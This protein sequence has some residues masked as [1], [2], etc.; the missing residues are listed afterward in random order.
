VEVEVEAA[1]PAL[2][3]GGRSIPLV[4]PDRHDPRL[5]LAVVILSLQA[6][7]QIG[8]GFRVSIAQILVAIGVCALI[9]LAVVLHRERKLAWPASALLTGN[10]VAFILRTPGTHHGDWWSFNGIGL[11]IAASAIS[12]LSKYLVRPGGRHRFNPSNLGLVVVFLLLGPQ[13]A[14]PQY[15]WWGGLDVP[16]V[17]ALA[18][19]VI[20]GLWVLRPLR[21]LP[22]VLAFLL[23]F[24][25]ATAGL[26]ASGSCFLAIWS[27]APVCGTAYWLNLATSPELLV[28]VFFMITDPVTAPRG[29]GARVV[30]GV[31][32]AGAAAALIA[33]QPSEFGVKVALLAGLTVVCAVAPWLDRGLGRAAVPTPR[34]RVLHLT[35]A[36][37]VVLLIAA[38]IPLGV[39]ARAGDP[40]ILA[41]DRNPAIPAPPGAP[42]PVPQG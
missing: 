28:F 22:L 35:A 5:R 15:L 25:A 29:G 32:V 31:L 42:S 36:G 27:A 17:L 34:R 30:F 12:M 18:V 20:G 16:V 11:F 8:L 41:T 38:A 9:E 24:W 37:V 1:A 6:L 26:A 2:R 40:V 14:F 10:S 19:I 4:L 33:T 39:L 7:G 3:V 13:Y 21:L 23:T